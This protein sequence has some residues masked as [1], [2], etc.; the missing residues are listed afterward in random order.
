MKQKNKENQKYL[1][2]SNF[3]TQSIFENINEVHKDI[4][5]V[6]QQ[7]IDF[8][9]DEC[10]DLINISYNDYL[11]AK[12]LNKNEAYSFE[13]WKKFT[14]N[15]ITF[16]GIF[17]N[18]ITNQLV[19][20]NLI[21]TVRIDIDNP[22]N[23]N[24]KLAEFGLIFFYKNKMEEYV[25]DLN[26]NQINKK[27]IGYTRIHNNVIKINSA[28]R[29]KFY[30]LL[31]QYKETGIYKTNFN[32][33]K[34]ILGIVELYNEDNKKISINDP[35]YRIIFSENN[36][37][38][39]IKKDIY[40]KFSQFDHKFLRPTIDYFNNNK[41][42]DIHNIVYTTIKKGRKTIG[43]EFRFISRGQNLNE[44]QLTCKETFIHYGLEETQI[45]YL[46]KRIGVRECY[47]R[48]KQYVTIKQE[49]TTKVY[50]ERH[51]NKQIDNLGG[52]LYTKVFKSELN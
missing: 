5:Y 47:G 45:I 37:D 34:I 36:V 20:F 28:R 44:E 24:I 38:S 19:N 9:S 48:F 35:Q 7:K 40:K 18:K 22:E 32:Y 23:L 8:Y 49:G 31:S 15:L 33:L 30:E 42:L 29:K 51:S 6:L 46:M 50:Y 52:Y 41:E 16:N 21:S 2:Q 1:I 39:Y 17:I 26:N 13:E 11:S 25:K 14:E 10:E 12:N 43:I 4:I 27:Q 3:F